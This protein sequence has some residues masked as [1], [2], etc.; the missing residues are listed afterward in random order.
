MCEIGVSCI[1]VGGKNY[2]PFIKLACSLG[3]PVFVV[4]DNDGNTQNEIDAQISNIKRD[5][6]LELGDDLFGVSYLSQGNDFE[7][8]V[9]ASLGLR[10]EIVEA[11]V[12]CE[13]R[14][15]VNVNWVSAK[16]RELSALSDDQVLRKMGELKASYSGYL[17]DILIANAA[18]RT[19]EQR[20]PSAI[21]VAFDSIKEWL[22]Y[23]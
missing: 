8:E 21:L 19:K 14:G 17:G 18:G 11:L 15:A 22:R 3:I 16:H 4:S 5:S 13:T 20:I 9:F 6:L 23:D 1:S 7:A 12:K 2:A 10:P